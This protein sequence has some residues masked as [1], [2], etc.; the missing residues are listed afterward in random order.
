MAIARRSLLILAPAAIL[1]PVAARAATDAAMAER[2]LGRADAPVVVHEWFSLTCPHCARFARD[3]FPRIQSELID[4]GKLRYV[5]GDYP[6]DQVALAAAQVARALPAERYAPFVDALLATQDRWAFARGVNST[7]ELAKMAALAGLSR[8]AF[9]AAIGDTALRDAILAA[10]DQ[11]TKT[12]E[13][14]STPTFIFDGPGAKARK[15][16]GELSYDKFAATVAEA[17]GSA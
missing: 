13:V 10:Q 17:A 11:A 9:D 1:A 4:A 14:N 2:A 16:S 15:E 8:P 5:Y 7:E 3:V 6:L 12:Y